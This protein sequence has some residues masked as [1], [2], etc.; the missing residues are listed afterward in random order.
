[1]ALHSPDPLALPWIAEAL[2][3]LRGGLRSLLGMGHAGPASRWRAGN[4]TARIG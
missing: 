3:T 4:E 2:D 1:M